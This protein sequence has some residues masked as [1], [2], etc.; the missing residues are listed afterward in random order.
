MSI[1][2]NKD[3]LNTLTRDEGAEIITA[4]NK[5]NG[6]IEEDGD[7]LSQENRKSTGI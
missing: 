7:F 3:I 6:L 4:I 2:G 5:L 1:D